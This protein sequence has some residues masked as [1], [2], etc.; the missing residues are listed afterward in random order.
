MILVVAITYFPV[1]HIILLRNVNFYVKY[2]FLFDTTVFRA[3]QDFSV[4]PNV[5]IN[6][7]VNKEKQMLAIKKI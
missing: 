5:S 7:I 2:F 3:T 6:N 4:L 1:T